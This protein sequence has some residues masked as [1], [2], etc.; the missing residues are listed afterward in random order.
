LRDLVNTFAYR[1]P[2]YPTSHELVDR[3]KAQTPPE[4]HYLIQDLFEEITLFSNR[5]LETTAKKLPDGTYEVTVKAEAKKLKADDQGNEKVV[6]LKDWIEIGAFAAPEK[7]RKYGATLYR[8]R[9]L[10]DKPE[11]THTFVVT[12][13]PEKVG[14]D[15]FNLL[16]DRIPD[17]NTRDV[18][19]Q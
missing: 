14:I 19:V 10:I 4:Y 6:P 17:D 1:N 9:L 12:S 5:T 18:S 15:P 2:P 7:G 11:V 13:L 3:L 16:V 8:E